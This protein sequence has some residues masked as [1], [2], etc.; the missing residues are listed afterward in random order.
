VTLAGQ[1]AGATLAL[2]TA[3]ALVTGD[4]AVAGGTRGV[5]VAAPRAV[6]A[7]YPVVDMAR[8]AP[9]LQQAVFGGPA[10]ERPEPL[11]AASPD[12]QVRPGLPPTLLVLGAADHFVFADTVRAYDAALRRVG[13]PGR[14]LV[15]PYADHVF[16]YPFGSPGG[17]TAR[18]VLEGFVREYGAA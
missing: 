9:S 5:P 15:V 13:T 14:L 2:A 17:Q 12:R 10:R 8:I 16:D 18:V 6:A 11:R 1:S 4:P 7:F 3:S